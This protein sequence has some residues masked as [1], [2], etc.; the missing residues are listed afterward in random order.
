ME[1]LCLWGQ[2]GSHLLPWVGVGS[3]DSNLGP[4]TLTESLLPGLYFSMCKCMPMSQGDTGGR[5]S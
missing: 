4:I 5:N 2:Q 1:A 3:L